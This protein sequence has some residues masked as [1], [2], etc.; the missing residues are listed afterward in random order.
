MPKFFA[1][2]RG[3]EHLSVTSAS[4]DLVLKEILF[5]QCRSDG[6]G[7]PFSSSPQPGDAPNTLRVTT[8]VRESSEGFSRS[9]CSS[10]CFSVSTTFF[11]S[12][13]QR[14]AML[15]LAQTPI[16]CTKRTLLLLSCWNFNSLIGLGTNQ[17]ISLVVHLI[18]PIR[19]GKGW[20][21]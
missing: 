20:R 1:S 10:C 19:F 14:P 2:T 7:N 21:R 17:C 4:S 5:M 6:I 12:E 3:T 9:S 18:A 16:S 8:S 13:I 11:F 15:L